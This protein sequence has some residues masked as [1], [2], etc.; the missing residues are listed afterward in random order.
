MLAKEFVNSIDD[1]IILIGLLLPLAAWT[2]YAYRKRAYNVRS[3][4]S[5]ILIWSVSLAL[6]GRAFMREIAG[7]DN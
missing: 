1:Y 5:L 7:I 6:L 2:F 3:L 4:L